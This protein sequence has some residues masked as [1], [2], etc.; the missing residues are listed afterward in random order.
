MI[1]Y[2]WILS[3]VDVV[4]IAF[5]SIEGVEVWYSLISYVWVL[6]IVPVVWSVFK[7]IDGEDA[8]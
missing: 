2:D 1:S 4:W 3:I 8:W 7:S 6:S 5:K